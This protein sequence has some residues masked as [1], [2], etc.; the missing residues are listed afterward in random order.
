[1]SEPKSTFVTCP[2][3]NCSNHIEF[4]ASEF[5]EGE[6]RTIECPHCKSETVIF[7]PQKPKPPSTPAPA[8]PLPT[9]PPPPPNQGETRKG[10]GKSER[11]LDYL[12]KEMTIMGVLSTFCLAIPSLFFERVISADQNSIAHDFLAALWH[13]GT[14]YLVF[15]S[16]LMLAGAALFYR[17][18]S[19]LAWYY[20][21]IAL[22]MAL[23]DYTTPS[24]EQW[25][26]ESDSW[27]T[28][29][30]YHWAYWTVIFAT[31]GFVLAILSVYVQFIQTHWWC[32]VGILVVALVLVV[33]L[34][35]RNSMKHAYDEN[36]HFFRIH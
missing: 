16:V 11:Y 18:R 14:P 8:M 3:Q 9:N 13:G 34:I 28:W 2:C 10:S 25:L 17:Q 33:K 26:K 12:D 35:R 21:Q 4:D 30:K 19:L 6:T 24:L 23:P 32:F 27:E 31:A 7:V 22:K 1:M 20:G 5:D 36:P 15:A 29:I